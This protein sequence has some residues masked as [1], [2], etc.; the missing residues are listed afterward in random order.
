M[1]KYILLLLALIVIPMG[2][3]DAQGK[4]K[5]G[6]KEVSPVL[7][8]RKKV[9]KTDYE[10]VWKFTSFNAKK[11][12]MYFCD[13]DYLTIPD[14]VSQKKPDW[15][16]FQPVANFMTNNG[17]VAMTMVAIYGINPSITE[18]SDRERLAKQANDTAL[19]AL[20][21]FEE[22]M[23][24]QGMKNKMV[25]QVAQVDFRYWH[26]TEFFNMTMPQEDVIPLG[27]IIALTNKKVEIFPDPSAGAQSFKDIKFFPNDA[28]I[29]ESY[30][31]LID[32]VASYVMSND[33]YEVLLTGYSDNVGTVAYNKGLSHQR[34]MEIKKMLLQR[35][36]PDYRIEI[37]ARGENDPIGDNNTYEG[38]IANNR[39][40]IKIQ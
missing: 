32:S 15:Q 31:P 25:F 10:A 28:S 26:G 20:K 22:W 19:G 8:G 9:R 6:K 38:R 40:S 33:R 11:K 12:T 13:F 4:K 30:Y 24:S 17:R 2:A 7:E 5:K 34:A 27:F 36:V 23:T 14:I 3:I 16:G 29:V 37:V 21:A 1:K 35:G 39:V 18:D